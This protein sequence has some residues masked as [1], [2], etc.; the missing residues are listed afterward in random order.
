[1]VLAVVRG[2]AGGSPTTPGHAAP[3]GLP[4]TPGEVEVVDGEVRAAVV[5]LLVAD[6]ADD[7]VRAEAARVAHDWPAAGAALNHLVFST[8]GT[9]R[10]AAL[11]ALVHRDAAPDLLEAF[12]DGV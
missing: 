4:P 11:V 6:A 3:R 8:S 2:G 7:R 9:V 12:R 5:A 1:E 10:A